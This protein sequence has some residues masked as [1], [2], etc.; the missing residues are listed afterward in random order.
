VVWNLAGMEENL[1]FAHGHHSSNIKTKKRGISKRKKICEACQKKRR[2]RTGRK[3]HRGNKGSQGARYSDLRSKKERMS[4][5]C[6]RQ[7]KL[8]EGMNN[9]HATKKR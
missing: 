7:K 8:L 3:G 1:G 6:K 5:I 4:K 9:E 2:D